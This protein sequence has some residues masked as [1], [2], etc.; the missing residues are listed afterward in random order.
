MARHEPARPP[1]DVPAAAAGG[2]AE[3]DAGDRARWLVPGIV[4]LG[5][6]AVGSLAA[7]SSPTLR[8][9]PEASLY[10]GDWTSALEAELMDGTFL[11]AAATAAWGVIDLTVFG[12]GLPGVLVGSDGWLFTTEEFAASEVDARFTTPTPIGE[13]RSVRERLTGDG[14]ELVVVLVPAKAR[15]H[16]EALGRYALPPDAEARYG[17]LRSTLREAGVGVVDGAAAM[18]AVPAGEARF[19][20]T[21]THWTPAGARAVAER[22]ARRI[23]RVAAGAPW[24]GRTPHRIEPRETLR[25]EGDL[26]AFVPLGPFAGAVAPPPDR[27]APFEAVREGGPG[28][29]LFAEPD[30]AVTLVGTSYSADARWGFADA[31]RGALGAG[32]LVA[33]SEGSGPFDPMRSYLDGEAYRSSRPDVVVWEIPERYV[34]PEVGW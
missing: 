30:L 14:V 29:D 16:D 6:L 5:I 10:D 20:R 2:P 19:L 23:E 24:L 33:A 8:S 13:I 11:G 31:L 12:Q 17:V 21:D 28:T 32:V 34:W 27:V 9:P 3:L 1:S 22:T 18:D 25:V 4:L 7:L 26:L 15:V